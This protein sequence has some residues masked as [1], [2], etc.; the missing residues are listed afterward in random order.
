MDIF[1][2]S[3]GGLSC[4]DIVLVRSFLTFSVSRSTILG[5]TLD[6]NAVKD[7]AATLSLLTNGSR[8][9][10]VLYASAISLSRFRTAPTAASHA[11][12]AIA[13]RFSLALAVID[14]LIGNSA[15]YESTQWESFAK[16]GSTVPR[17]RTCIP[18]LLTGSIVFFVIFHYH[19]N[20]SFFGAHGRSGQ[21]R[22]VSILGIRTH[23]F[24]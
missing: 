15:W 10:A 7:L 6:F 3:L 9:A 18:G 11:V 4:V 8:G 22:F 14:T 24:A 23:R 20:S 5:N 12:R 21:R 1:R 16:D 13:T 2:N 17:S 19:Y